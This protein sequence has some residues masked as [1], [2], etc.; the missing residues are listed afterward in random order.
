MAKK[1]KHDPMAQLATQELDKERRKRL[2]KIQEEW[3][4]GTNL[5][6]ERL[7]LPDLRLLLEHH[8]PLQDLIRAIV[9]TAQGGSP[10]AAAKQTGELREQLEDAMATAQAAT[11]AQEEAEATAQ[12]LR[13][14]CRGLQHDLDQ[15]S[16]AT[17]KLQQEKSSAQETL[18]QL[19]KQLQQV[20]KE[21]AAARAELA[22]AGTAPVELKLLQNDAELARRLELT[23]LP[24]DTTQALIR[25]VAVLA[26]R[27]SLERLWASLKERCESEN[28]AAHAEERA[29][30]AAALSWYNHNW[31]NKPYQLAEAAVGTS[32]DY[33]RHLR[34]QHT[35]SGE[36]ISE[37]RLP[38]IADGSGRLICKALVSTR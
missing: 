20:Q 32:Y 26:Q 29:L 23:D 24:S 36:K 16:A 7:S 34:S 4:G 22:R 10:A 21:L 17:Q 38:G 35:T 33:E 2:E 37:F 18:R 5:F 1:D 25:V 15:C 27:D 14:Q 9:G 3:D 12:A 31:H 8:A 13:E 11:A 28:R 19:E 30:L 6:P